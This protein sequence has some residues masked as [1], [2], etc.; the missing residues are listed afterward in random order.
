MC[1][2]VARLHC[3]KARAVLGP[4]IFNRILA[5]STTIISSGVS[6]S[7]EPDGRLAYYSRTMEGRISLGESKRM[8]E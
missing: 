2:V 5:T 6:P 4:S 8:I 1:D 3:Q 7:P